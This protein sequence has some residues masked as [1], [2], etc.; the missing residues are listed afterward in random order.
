MLYVKDLIKAI[1]SPSPSL[2]KA[3]LFKF[4]TR[5]SVFVVHKIMALNFYHIKL[6][7]GNGRE[8]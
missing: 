4:K 5:T 6:G 7:N 8:T 3:N 2:I 1:K